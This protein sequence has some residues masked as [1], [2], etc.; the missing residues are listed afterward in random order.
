MKSEVWMISHCLDLGPETMV[1]AACLTMIL[2]YTH[3]FENNEP[4]D[5]TVV[6]ENVQTRMST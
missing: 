2:S 4:T 5:N 3:V 1:R 6:L